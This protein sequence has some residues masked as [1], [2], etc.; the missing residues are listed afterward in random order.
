MTVTVDNR[1]TSL[2]TVDNLA[3]T[4]HCTQC[5]AWPPLAVSLA[6]GHYALQVSL[7]QSDWCSF[8]VN[9]TDEWPFTAASVSLIPQEKTVGSRTAA[10]A[11]AVVAGC[12]RGS[13]RVGLW[14]RGWL[15]LGVWS[16]VT[17]TALIRRGQ[18]NRGQY[19][20][21]PCLA[22]PTAINSHPDR[23]TDR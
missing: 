11:A 3:V 1:R 4:I 13:A 18:G 12:S 14:S 5:T 21:F 7:E 20:P 19:H 23:E 16:H 10:A 17:E 9:L 15:A 6:L 2:T 8:H 22:R